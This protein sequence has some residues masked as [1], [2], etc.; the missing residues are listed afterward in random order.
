MKSLSLV[1]MATFFYAFVAV[2]SWGWA[3][4]TG[5]AG[6]LLGEQPAEVKHILMGVTVGIVIATICQIANALFKPI[7]R[8]SR[9]L[10]AFFGPIRVSEAIY[11]AVLSGLAE[12]IC[13]RGALW[14]QLG[15]WGSAILFGMLHI[16]PMRALMGYPVFAILAGLVFGL[17]RESSGSVWPA[18]VAHAT[19]NALNLSWLGAM[20]R[21]RR[22]G[23][24]E[25]GPLPALPRRDEPAPVDTKVDDSFPLTV[26]RYD[27]RVELTGTDRESLPQCLEHEQLH[28]CRFVPREE[29]YRQF[30]DGLFV[31][32]E[33]S[34]EP[35]PGFAEDIATLSAYLPETLMGVEVAERFVDETTT[36]DIQA[37]KVVAQRGEW[38]KV[39]LLVAPPED[40]KFTVD[41]DKEDVE[42]IAAKWNEYPRWFQDGMRFKYPRLREL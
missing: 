11:L 7:E 6:V 18:V 4:V 3:K 22:V 8:A 13:F 35:F 20:E 25:A 24:A 12:E 39:P 27:L 41:P 31:F 14:P 1:R 19:V 21:R 23:E 2:A 33:T 10:G 9:L 26:W 15:L 37:W 28:L 34:K 30:R 36:D 29:V 17:L 38:T 5:N 32:V 16:V 42:V 40:G